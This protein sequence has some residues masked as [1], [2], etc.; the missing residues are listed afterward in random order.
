VLDMNADQIRA[1]VLFDALPNGAPHT[2]VIRLTRRAL[3]VA[4]R[5]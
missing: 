2:A 4:R 3:I 1:V 5:V